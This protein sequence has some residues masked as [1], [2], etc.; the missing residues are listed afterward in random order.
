MSESELNSYRFLSGTEP[1]DEQ[2]HAIMEAA[3]VDVR[4][5]AEKAQKEYAEQYNQ[6][7]A[8][9]HSRLAQRIENARNGIFW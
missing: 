1:T 8:R 7:Y 6:L 9:E 4:H 2:L 3:L 5:R